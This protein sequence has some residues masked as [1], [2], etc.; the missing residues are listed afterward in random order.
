MSRNMLSLGQAAIILMALMLAGGLASAADFEVAAGKVVVEEDFP[1]DSKFNDK[2]G[3]KPVIPMDTEDPTYDMWKT[4]RTDLAEGRDPGP[5]DIQRMPFGF[6]FTGIPTFF[7]LPIALT[8]EDLKVGDVD[9]AFLGAYTD[10][11]GGQRGANRGPAALRAS[12]AEY[13][14]WGAASMSHMGTLVNPFK[15]MSV[16]DY[17]DAP[18]D[19][20]STH[21][22]N[23]AVR[24]MVRE[25]ASVERKDGSQVIPFVIGGDHSLS[26]PTI[27]AAADVYGKGNV[28]VIHFDAH[29]DGTLLLGHLAGHG[30]WVKQ[31]IVE[32]HVPGKNYIQVGLRGYYPDKESFE[33]MQEEG[34]RYHTMAEID[35]RGWPV[36]M[37]EI[38]K[39]AQEGPEYLYISF[40]I[41]VLDPAYMPGTGTPEPGGLTTREAFPIM[42]RLCAETNVIGVDMLELAPERDPGYTTVHNTNRLVRECLVG[43]AMR[44][45]GIT[46]EN[47]LNPLTKGDGYK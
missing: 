12:A 26:Y 18:V 22:T 16:V 10:M 4:M 20:W 21:R 29:Y 6:G 35:D 31:L 44:K 42:R 27:A 45:Q 23:E 19:P 15:D 28:G 13:V 47:Y 38:I 17:G 32:G 46:E 2:P 39:E 43:M 33:W 30:A 37:E 36:V 40:D 41:D 25:I 1:A 24:A 11:G 3:V 7:R 14:S 5:I 8:P 34:F 9:V